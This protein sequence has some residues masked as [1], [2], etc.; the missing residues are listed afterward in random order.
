M[1]EDFTPPAPSRDDLLAA[2]VEIEAENRR[3][4]REITRLRE[5]LQPVSREIETILS[6]LD[7][8]PR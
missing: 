5:A 1:A 7:E 4:I 2:L 8:M 6:L 3:L